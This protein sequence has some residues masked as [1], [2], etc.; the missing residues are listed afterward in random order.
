MD[1]ARIASLKWT[2]IPWM[3]FLLSLAARW[4]MRCVQL[5]ASMPKLPKRSSVRRNHF[6]MQ[7]NELV[8]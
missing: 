1:E 5:L 8:A 6:G 2:V 7:W 3:I 4:L